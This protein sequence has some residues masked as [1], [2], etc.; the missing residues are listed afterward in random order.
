MP[1]TDFFIS[2][3]IVSPH[4]TLAS[5]AHRRTRLVS[6]FRSSVYATYVDAMVEEEGVSGREDGDVGMRGEQEQDE[7]D[8][9][10]GEMREKLFWRRKKWFTSSL[11]TKMQWRRR[12][13]DQKVPLLK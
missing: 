6:S 12:T 5:P 3:V 2:P 1:D 11:W 7:E 13:R 4:L 9:E 8:E 10:E